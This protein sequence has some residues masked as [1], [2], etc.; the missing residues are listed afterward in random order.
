MKAGTK[1]HKSFIERMDIIL[2]PSS[3]KK[4]RA[5][6]IAGDTMMLDDADLSFREMFSPTSWSKPKVRSVKSKSAV[7]DMLDGSLRARHEAMH[8][9]VDTSSSRTDFNAGNI[10]PKKLS[11]AE[12][13]FSNVEEVD[14]EDHHFNE[15]SS[16]KNATFEKFDFDKYRFDLD[17]PQPNQTNSQV[18]LHDQ[19]PSSAEGIKM[20]LQAEY[21]RRRDRRSL[22]CGQKYREQL[23]SLGLVLVCVATIVGVFTLVIAKDNKGDNELA[24]QLLGEDNI[25]TSRKDEVIDFLFNLGV[26]PL[27]ALIDRTFPQH[28]AAMFVADGDAYRMEYNNANTEKEETTVETDVQGMATRRFVERY[29]LAVLYYHFEGDQWNSRLNFLSAQDH[30][31]WYDALER[32]NASTDS[33][34]KGEKKLIRLGVECN[35]DGFVKKIDLSQ[36]NLNGRNIPI[37][38]KSFNHLESLHMYY[39]TGI[40]GSVFP[41]SIREIKQSLKSIALMNTG[42]TGPI[43]NWIGEMTQLT[44]LALGKNQLNGSIPTSL[45]RLTKLQLLGLDNNDGLTG[46]LM[47]LFSSMSNL[48]ALYLNNNAL[49][50]QLPSDTKTWPQLGELDISNNL[51]DEQL[52]AALINHR[53]LRVLDV[54]KNMLSGQFPSDIF[55]NTILQVLAI[56]S[57]LIRGTIPDRLPFLQ[58][59]QHLD[60]SNNFLNGTIPDN[61]SQLTSL[62]YWSTSNNPFS[63]TGQLVPDLSRMSNLIVL[64]MKHNSL[65]GSVPDWVGELDKLKVLD[66]DTNALTG[67][68]P[69]WIGIAGNLHHIMFNRNQLTGTIPTEIVRL[70]HLETLMLDKNS[71]VG[72][73]QAI[74]NTEATNN[75]IALEL[76]HFTTD[77][78]PGRHG[79]KPEIDCRCCTT[80]CADDDLDCNNNFPYTTIN[81]DEIHS[82]REYGSLYRLPTTKDHVLNTKDNAT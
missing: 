47:N 8:G 24:E 45:S 16:L 18:N 51:I 13:L 59:L 66:L 55:Q 5:S 30:C 6:V 4:P 77:C 35:E 9:R 65:V 60:L 49:S 71:I 26:S 10:A 32:S 46:N 67:S 22:L 23:G 50:G 62:K 82:V 19:L 43:P 80:C 79:E 69:S 39:N 73:A 53:K 2:S 54:H 25:P 70:Q 14:L 40:H 42:L 20:H 72:N 76:T 27:P 36:N 58:S 64:S 33:S 21:F 12:N 3:T 34:P 44:T 78:Y 56:Q 7:V 68:I 52:P 28:K 74:C 57:N 41:E 15:P 29:A 48:E 37:E 81:S 63:S 17:D 1:S 31:N 11:S 75:N 38:M 61:M